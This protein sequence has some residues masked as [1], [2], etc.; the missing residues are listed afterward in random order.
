M[1][2]RHDLDLGQTPVVEHEIKL[3]PNSQPFHE[4]YHPIPQSMYEK[5]R[6]HLQEMLEVGAIRTSSSLWASAVVLGWKW[7]VKLQFCI[8]LCRLNNMTV[9]DAYSLPWIQEM[10]ECL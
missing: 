5:V 6:K 3:V 7:D 8:N 9:K 1:F 10:L 2:T 4:R